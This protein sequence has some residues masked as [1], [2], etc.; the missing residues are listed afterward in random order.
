MIQKQG[1]AH[2]CMKRRVLYTLH[3]FYMFR[4]L[5]WPS[6]G[7]GITKD[8]HQMSAGSNLVRL[9]NKGE[10]PHHFPAPHPPVLPNFLSK[11]AGPPK[12]DIQR[13]KIMIPK[14]GNAHKC[15]KRRVLYTLHAFYMFRPIKWSSLGRWITKDIH[16]KLLFI[17][18]SFK[19]CVHCACATSRMM[20]SF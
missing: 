6:L 4:P 3:A 17:H 15:M 10:N 1:N 8:R 5:K 13:G 20:Q 2:K 12:I 19:S 7:R 14:Q 16:T 9:K 11:R 18:R